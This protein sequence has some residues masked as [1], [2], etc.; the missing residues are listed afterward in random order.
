MLSKSR[1]SRSL[2]NFQIRNFRA[3]VFLQ[4]TGHFDGTECTEAISLLVALSKH[5][6][7][8]QCF[9]P[10]KPQD[11][12]INHYNGEE[13]PENRNTL[14]ESARIARGDIK[15]LDLLKAGDFDCLFVPS[16][17]KMSNFREF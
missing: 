8:V 11:I 14:I 10:D 1:L 9:A 2:L 5:R 17:P 7:Q 12:V 16:G 15:A 6:A 3:A 4:G 13:L